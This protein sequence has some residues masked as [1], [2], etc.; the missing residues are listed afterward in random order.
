VSRNDQCPHCGKPLALAH[1]T[2]RAIREVLGLSMADIGKRLGVSGSYVCYLESGVRHPSGKVTGRYLKLQELVR[3]QRAN[4]AITA[5]P[6][7]V[8]AAL[9]A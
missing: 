7:Q 4:G 2:M 1:A 8:K 5:K 9:I 3:K 6:A